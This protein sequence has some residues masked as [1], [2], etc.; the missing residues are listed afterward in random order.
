MNKITLLS[1]LLISNAIGCTAQKTQERPVS[2][3]NKMKL[4]GSVNVIYTTSDSLS[5]KVM[6]EENDLDKVETKV[7]NGILVISNKG[8]FREEVYVYV[9]SKQLVSVESS[10]AT[11]FRVTN[12]LKG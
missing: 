11:D 3:F 9:K 7:E 5:L 8:R 10:G 4:S 1:I 12:F 6:A 2:E